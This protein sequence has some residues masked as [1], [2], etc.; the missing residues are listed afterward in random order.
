MPCRRATG[1]RGRRRSTGRHCRGGTVFARA[2]F[3]AAARPRCGCFGIPA[4]R[5]GSGP[6]G[7]DHRVQVGRDNH[8]PRAVHGPVGPS[9]SSARRSDVSGSRPEP[10]AAPRSSSQPHVIAVFNH[11]GG[12]GKT[13]TAVSVAA[14]LAMR[15][16]R[17]LLVDTDAQ[18]NVGV[19]L[20]VKAERSLY[21]VLVMG[22]RVADAVTRSA[23]NLD[24]VAFERDP[25]RRR[26]LPRRPPEP[27][28]RA[29]RSASSPREERVRLRGARLL[30]EPLAHEP[31]RAGLRRQRARAG[32]VRLPLARRRAAGHQDGQ[33]R[34]PAA[35]PPGADLG[36]CCRRSTTRRA[37]I[38]REAVGTMQDHFGERCLPPIRAA[39]KVK[40]APA[41]GQTIFEYARGLDTPRKTTCGW[42]I[43][44]SARAADA[45]QPSATRRSRCL[46]SQRRRR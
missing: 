14:G 36:A 20:G 5:V 6:D 26:A 43:G 23:P 9:V 11:K 15:G 37:R 16:K 32:G 30:A 41:Q 13:T 35:S 10:Q 39:M 27:R 34:Q 22:L 12:T 24:L 33:E 7:I 29:R 2:A 19:S 42:S 17:V 25:R 46:A 40:E 21:H 18:G 1:A 44:C 28:P 4:N 45:R 31:E 38:C 3:R 8:T